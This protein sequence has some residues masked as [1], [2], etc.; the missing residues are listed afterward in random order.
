M[1][2]GGEEVKA[3]ETGKKQNRL[4]RGDSDGEIKFKGEGIEGK[5]KIT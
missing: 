3:A 2:D 4:K 5:T 1:G